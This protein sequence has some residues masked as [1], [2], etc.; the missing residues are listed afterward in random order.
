MW[1]KYTIDFLYKTIMA[2]YKLVET[3]SILNQRMSVNV[4]EMCGDP[5]EFCNIIGSL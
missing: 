2:A 5:T 3:F 4:G 1:Q